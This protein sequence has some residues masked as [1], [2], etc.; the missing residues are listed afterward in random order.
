MLLGLPEFEILF[1]Q[2]L[3]EACSM[4]V[5]HGDDSK[6]IAGG[7]DL[8]I[9]MKHKRKLP[10]VLINIKRIA[11]LDHIEFDPEA[12]LRIGALAT[13]WT[14]GQSPAVKRLSRALWQ[15]AGV[16]GTAQIR[17]LATIG[18]NLANASPSA[19]FAPPLLALEGSLKFVG[20]EGERRMALDEF[21]LA[22]GR[23]ALGPAE[24]LAEVQVPIPA[25]HVADIYIKHSLRRM[26]VAMASVAVFAE[27]EE[28]TC[29]DVRIALGAVAPTPFRALAAEGILRGEKISGSAGDRLIERAAEAATGESTPIDDIR[30]YAGYRKKIVREIVGRGLR[31]VIA[32]IMNSRELS[33]A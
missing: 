16:L 33:P 28:E 15:S 26:D 12:G 20:P 31:Q 24:I 30:S 14:I 3:E 19:E 8:L 7:T 1:P 18:G 2:T 13:A 22:P 25:A 4:L 9:A 6:L 32:E 17:N 29:V 27:I 23:N 21:F 10:R 11:G 5:E